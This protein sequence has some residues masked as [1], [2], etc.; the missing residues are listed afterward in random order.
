MAPCAYRPVAR[1]VMAT[2][3]RTGSPSYK[4]LDHRADVGSYNK[5][6]QNDNR[7]LVKRPPTSGPV[8]CIIPDS[9]DAMES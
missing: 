3:G 7:H 5:T 9:A 2:P 4:G 8:M 1:S 6:R